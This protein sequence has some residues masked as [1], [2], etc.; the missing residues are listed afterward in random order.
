M[1]ALECVFNVLTLCQTQRRV[2][3]SVQG[4]WGP[5]AEGSWESRNQTGKHAELLTL[6]VAL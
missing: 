3:Q 6:S 5:L 1:N 4:A 2:D